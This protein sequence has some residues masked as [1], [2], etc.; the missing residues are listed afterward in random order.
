MLSQF[1]S[2]LPSRPLLSHSIGLSLQPGDVAERVHQ[3]RG[4]GMP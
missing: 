1:A 3:M 4:G 2:S